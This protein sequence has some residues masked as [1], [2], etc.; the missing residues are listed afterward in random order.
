MSYATAFHLLDGHGST[1]PGWIDRYF[2]QTLATSVAF[3]VLVFIVLVS[4]RV[5]PI[6][7]RPLASYQ[8]ELVDLSQHQASP[9]AAKKSTPV[10]PAEPPRVETPPPVPIPQERLAETFAGALK[11]VAVPDA[12]AIP[13][14]PNHRAP[15]TE[16]VTPVPSELKDQPLNLQAPPDVSQLATRERPRGVQKSQAVVPSTSSSAAKSL[17]Q[18]VES[19]AV[20]SITHPSS[21]MVPAESKAAS[22]KAPERKRTLLASKGITLPPEAP[23]LSAT[24]PMETLPD[25]PA[26]RA[27]KN[28]LSEA[29]QQAVQSVVIPD[30]KA[31]KPVSQTPVSTVASRKPVQNESV[32][33]KM[34]LPPQA[35]KLATVEPSAST[36]NRP[37]RETI[38]SPDRNELGSR[39]AK[40]TI[41][42][43]DVSQQH[44]TLNGTTSNKVKTKTKLKVA[45][46]SPDGNPYWGRVWAKIDQE[47]V[48]PPVNIHQGNV[49]Q[50]ILEFR[51]ERTGGVRNLSIQQ[52]SGNEYYDLA[53]KRA[54][55]AAVPL[56]GFPPDMTEQHFTLQF[57]FTVNER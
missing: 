27:K 33:P 22:P 53:A 18:S 35:P 25:R 34:V 16:N 24:A 12:R 57:Q 46:S 47:W 52:S 26:K 21:Q 45:G 37:T 4:I 39:I 2:K 14:A 56:P 41:P 23:R 29:L 13:P 38:P 15:G 7:D 48:A 5:T 36:S 42:D 20:P 9:T 19:V 30:M 6:H 50:V 32:M 11:Q 44:E 55:L 40:L 51:L 31:S 1:Q 28:P 8:I 10:T 54:V 43:V 49:L 3:H 17:Q